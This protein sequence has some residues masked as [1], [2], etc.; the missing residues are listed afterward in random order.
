MISLF[1]FSFKI[2]Y[3]E[4]VS[5]T[6]VCFYGKSGRSPLVIEDGMEVD[7]NVRIWWRE[8]QIRYGTNAPVKPCILIMMH[9]P[10][11]VFAQICIH[12][13]IDPKKWGSTY[14]AGAEVTYRWVLNSVQYVLENNFADS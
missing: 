11:L 2:S 14:F 13:Y 3:F 5:F 8:V 6:I 9:L 1:S 7:I 10:R 12:V 4:H